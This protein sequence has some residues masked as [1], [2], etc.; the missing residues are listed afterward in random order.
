MEVRLSPGSRAAAAYG[1]LS[2]TEAYYCNFG[3]NPAVT[4]E[5]F[6]RDLVVS[7]TDQDGEPRV[8]ELPGHRFFVATL[9]VPQ[10]QSRPG[11]P[12]PLVLAWLAI[13]A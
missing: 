5:L 12:H 6:S 3:I 2:T 13:A 9:Y 7:G 8:I 11:E 1:R 4:G 10:M